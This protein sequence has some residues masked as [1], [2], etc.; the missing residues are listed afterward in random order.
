MTDDIH[1]ALNVTRD[2]GVKTIPPT[3]A[4]QVGVHAGSEHVC[5]GLGIIFMVIG[6]YLLLNPTGAD[7]DTLGSRV[8]NLQ[9]LDIGETCAIVGAIFLAAG[10]RPR[11]TR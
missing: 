4:P 11:L 9:L 8:V 2:D 7:A 5:V 3:S 1:D 10:I 6:F